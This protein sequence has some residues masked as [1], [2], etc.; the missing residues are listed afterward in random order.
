[1]GVEGV[2]KERQGEGRNRRKVRMRERTRG[3]SE[4]SEKEGDVREKR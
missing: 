1:M 2:M 4:V 3:K